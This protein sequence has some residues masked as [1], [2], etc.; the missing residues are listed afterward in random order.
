MVDPG[1]PD[2]QPGFIAPVTVRIASAFQPF[3][4]INKLLRTG[5]AELVG[6]SATIRLNAAPVRTR[7]VN[8]QTAFFAID[9]TAGALKKTF[10]R[11]LLAAIQLG[12]FLQPGA[13]EFIAYGNNFG[14]GIPNGFNRRLN[15]EKYSIA[16]NALSIW[17]QVGSAVAITITQPV[18]S[19][20]DSRDSEP[21]SAFTG[22]NAVLSLGHILW[23][24][25][26]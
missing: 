22:E 8:R 24:K 13:I 4:V 5:V 26:Q 19:S 2:F 7:R 9:R 3:D 16:R 10:D 17:K 20:A 1:R 21:N 18:L 15:L 25:E 23:V 11:A 6:Y 12:V 14:H